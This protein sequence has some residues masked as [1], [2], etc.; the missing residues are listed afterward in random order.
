MFPND[1]FSLQLKMTSLM[2]DTQMVMTLRILGM[3]GAI[4]TPHGENGRMMEEKGP[5]M[6]SAFAAGTKAMMSGARPDQIMVAAM[7]PVS[8]RVS[9]N[10]ARLMK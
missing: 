6:A 10:R 4:P 9:S 5:A 3:S 7:A 2:V 1:L 8:K